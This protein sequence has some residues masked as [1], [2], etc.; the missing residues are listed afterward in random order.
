MVQMPKAYLSTISK[1][2]QILNLAKLYPWHNAADRRNGV[3]FAKLIGREANYLLAARVARESC[4]IK[5]HLD[6]LTKRESDF[7]DLVMR[8]ASESKKT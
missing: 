5:Y 8:D 2:Y 3:V 4:L 1:N 6:Q 7:A